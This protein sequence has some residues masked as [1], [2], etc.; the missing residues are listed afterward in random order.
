MHHT[1]FRA[2]GTDCR[3]GL[4]SGSRRSG[5]RV[6]HRKIHAPGKHS[7]PWDVESDNPAITWY[8]GMFKSEGGR[9]IKQGSI[10][11]SGAGAKRRNSPGKAELSSWSIVLAGGPDGVEL[12]TL[13]TSDEPSGRRAP[14]GGSEFEEAVAKNRNMRF[15]AVSTSVSSH[16]NHE[17]RV[18]KYQLPRAGKK[19]IP[20]K[21]VRASSPEAFTD[22]LTLVINKSGVQADANSVSIDLS[23]EMGHDGQSDRP[24]YGPGLSRDRQCRPGEPE[25]RQRPRQGFRSQAQGVAGKIQEDGAGSHA[26]MCSVSGKEPFPP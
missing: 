13:A 26:V 2:A 20:V 12:V 10:L 18:S 4:G 25:R 19:T 3:A 23:D 6:R 5:S 15:S 21:H 11:I 17:T 16:N 7:L 8:K 14:S 1:G 22:E 24:R 9:Q